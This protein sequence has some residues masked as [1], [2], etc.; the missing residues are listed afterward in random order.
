[1]AWMQN[2]TFLGEYFNFATL[3]GANI[4]ASKQFCDVREYNTVSI[5]PGITKHTE[6]QRQWL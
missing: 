1:M 6:G 4:S 5:L 2:Y 3:F